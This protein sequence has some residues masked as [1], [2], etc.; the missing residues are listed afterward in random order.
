MMQLRDAT[1]ADVEYVAAHLRAADV[2][3]LRA[4]G[5]PD[6]AEA[7]RES[8]RISTWTRAAVVG[9]DVAAV[10][11]VTPTAAP[12]VASP[13]MLGTDAIHRV[14]REFLRASVGEVERMMGDNL[15]LFN[16]VHVDNTVSLAW[17]RWLGFT[18]SD[19][20]AHDNPNFYDFW[21]A[22]KCATR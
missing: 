13:W 19:K 4:T 2:V 10:Y 16:R 21:K 20:P 9:D 3:E 8:A 1:P 14:G 18:I 7:V 11:G 5:L 6:P 17:L 12:G 15:L 22:N